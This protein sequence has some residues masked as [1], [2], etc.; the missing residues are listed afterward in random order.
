[1]TDRL[2]FKPALLAGRVSYDI[3]AT[4]VA[5][6][7]DGREM[8]RVN[9]GDLADLGQV[10]HRIGVTRTERLDLYLNDGSKRTIS[11]N[12]SYRSSKGPNYSGYRAVMSE[13]SAALHAARPD[14]SVTVGER[15]R[16]A[17]VMFGIGVVT[18]LFALG[19]AG[20]IMAQ[21]LSTNR[22]LDVA[23]PLIVMLLFGGFTAWK[24]RPGQ[25]LD[26]L[27][28]ARFTDVMHALAKGLK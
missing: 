17:M 10:S 1:M 13:L 3:A 28:I 2:S 26:R 14:L 18:L 7:K 4:S 23:A 8:W 6:I 16:T 22:Q 11:I 9:Y 21:G 12:A 5:Q 15:G 25:V 24:Y 27:P 19:F 20:V